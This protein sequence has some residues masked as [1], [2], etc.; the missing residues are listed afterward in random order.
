MIIQ[1]ISKEHRIP[2]P[3]ARDLGIV[4]IVALGVLAGVLIPVTGLLAG[5]QDGDGILT[6]LISTQKLT[7]YF[8]G[9]DRLL[10]F[11]PAIASPIA[12][13]EWNLRIQ[14]FLR[15]FFA[16]LA[17]TGLL[18][19]FNQS[20]RFIAFAVALTNFLIALTFSSQALSNLYVEPNPFGT[21]LVLLAL[22]LAAFR[23]GDTK[24]RWV[25]ASLLVGFFAYATNFALLSYSFPVI[26]IA[27][28]TGTLPRRQL[29]GFFVINIFCVM[30][31]YEHSKHFGHGITP[32]NRLHISGEAVAGG[33]LSVAANVSW[34]SLLA[35]GLFAI[36]FGCLVHPPHFMSA[37]LMMVASIAL[38]GILSCSIW[39]QINNYHIRYYIVFVISFISAISY[40]FSVWLYPILRNR[41][42][43]IPS[44]ATLLFVEVAFKLHGIS[45]DYAQ[46]I[47]MTWRN[48]SRAVAEA[49][50]INRAQLI[51]GDFWDVWPA[52]LDALTL[53]SDGKVY[54][55]TFRG[56][57]LTRRIQRLAQ[58]EHGIRVICF[59]TTIAACEDD[60]SSG[61][62]VQTSVVPGSANKITVENR[63]M[64][65]ATMTF[66]P[67]H[68]VK[69]LPR[70]NAT[71]ARSTLS[72]AGDPTFTPDAGTLRIP[73]ELSNLGTVE[74][75]SEGVHPIDLGVQLLSTSGKV[76]K[77]DFIRTTIPDIA[78][79]GQ[80]LVNISVPMTEISDR[81]L[82][83]LPIQEGVS[84]FDHFGVKG[85]IIGPFHAC[86]N[87][88]RPWM[89]DASGHALRASM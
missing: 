38:I 43:D 44:S 39:T 72:I 25:L 2:L 74:F 47:N 89:C 66:P 73:V 56:D 63:E 8:W 28:L 51:I 67:P 78:P 31:A 32:F 57:E 80:A 17:P 35:L 81:I 61:L 26:G 18:Y 79:G 55:A 68:D 69:T 71:Q 7:W 82:L 40:L 5:S 46:L 37:L 29:L 34:M 1:D 27:F 12:N 85:L 77:V 50:V 53:S 13:I 76:E 84:W 23:Q 62:H 41:R 52:V 14:I 49:A 19:F 33:Y 11:I 88:S 9:Q 42:L 36:V 60:A 3:A 24:V 70:L 21:S 87:D 15:A 4:W 45:P 10:N 22:S 58:D 20:T 6:A 65:L 30:L 64:L 16:F 75:T 48:R 59:H 54:G 86:S 83:I